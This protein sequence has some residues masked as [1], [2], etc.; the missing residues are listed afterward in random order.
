MEAHSYFYNK[1]LS[2]RN[3]KQSSN[4]SCRNYSSTPVLQQPK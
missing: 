3:E 4:R 1:S 2:K